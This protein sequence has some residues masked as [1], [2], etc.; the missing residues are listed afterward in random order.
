MKQQRSI[1]GRL[2]L[3]LSLSV[4]A[5][6]LISV[7]IAAVVLRGELNAAFDETMR[8]SA[9][10]LLPL[11]MHELDEVLEGDADDSE[12]NFIAN[13][14]RDDA[15]LDYFILDRSNRVLLFSGARPTDISSGS[16]PLGFSEWSGSRAYALTDAE[17]GFGIVVSERAGLRDNILIESILRMFLPLAVL[18]PI[19]AGLV[20]VIV[21]AAMAPILGLSAA[22]ARRHGRNLA[23]MDMGAQ[24]IELQPIVS[25]VE[26]L[27]VRLKSALDAER[28]FAAESAH[29]LRTPI[30]GALA[31]IQV[32]RS[33][34]DRAD[35]VQHLEQAEE[36]LRHLSHLSENLLQFSRLEAGFAS[37]EKETSLGVVIDIVLREKPFADAADRILIAGS[38]NT[39]LKA[40]ITADAFAIVLRNLLQN[41]LTYAP[42]GTPLKLVVEDREIRIT[43]ECDTLPTELLTTVTNRYVRGQTGHRGT[44]LGL[45]IVA[46]ILRDCEGQ[47]E[48]YSPIPGQQSGFEARVAFTRSQ[49]HIPMKEGTS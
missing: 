28:S 32:L 3:I 27:L 36:A 29:E 14:T 7:V 19:L 45:S 9:L 13:L 16:I 48:L 49:Q 37:S 26:D 21:K 23:P 18:I 33:K 5:L 2:A 15:N 24:P 12:A 20:F 1:A 41:A 6:W 31:Q 39:S 47:L 11:A 43:N 10:R 38:E 22:I 46:A 30:A 34:V 4:S 25:E 44:G 35:T 42:S 17:S 40:F 8:Q